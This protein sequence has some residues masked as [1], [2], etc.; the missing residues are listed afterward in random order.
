MELIVITVCIVALIVVLI[1]VPI[2]AVWLW[3]LI[4]ARNLRQDAINIY[5]DLR[6]PASPDLGVVQHRGS[7]GE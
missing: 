3:V 7:G 6:S 2:A 1:G 5:N 4:R